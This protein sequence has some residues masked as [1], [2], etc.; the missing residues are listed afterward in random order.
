M[1]A[2]K[3]ELEERLAQEKQEQ[4]NLRDHENQM[5]QT[6]LLNQVRWD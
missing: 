6:L 2:R 3:K 4:S 1:A 5:M